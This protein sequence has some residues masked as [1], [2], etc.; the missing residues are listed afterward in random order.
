VRS[1]QD[2]LDENREGV[3]GTVASARKALENFASASEQIRAVVEENRASLKSTIA[4]AEQ[5]TGEMKG[6]AAENRETLKA[7]IANA[8]RMTRE[9]ADLVAENRATVKAALERIEAASGQVA[10]LVEENRRNI[11]NTTAKLPGAVD[12][13]SQAAGQIRDAVAE[14]RDDLRST[15]LGVAAFAPKLDRIGDNLEKIT[16]Q[17]ASGKGTVGRLVFEDTIHDQASS[18]LTSA[19]ERMDEIKPFTQGISELKLY[20]GLEGGSNVDSGMMLGEGYLR[21]EP[22][23]WKFYQAGASY[24]WAPTDRKVEKDDPNKLGVDFSLLIGWRFMPDDGIER[25]RLSVAGGLIETRLGGWADVAI[26]R[27][28]DIRLMARLKHNDREP[29]DRRYE[30]GDAMVRATAS[31]RMFDRIYAI[32]GWDD[33]T[34]QDAGPWFA[35]RAELLDNDLRNLST[36]SSIAR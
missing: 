32:A 20:A 13:L 3:K 24:R 35:L 15:M 7:S 2:I 26:T 8:E 17:V 34:G 1:L 36:A 30:H 23:S 28:L 19:Q 16:A 9:I 25:Y 21:I 14:N 6:I 5:L 11:Q 27:D 31:Y 10:A 22:R 29:T 18:V 4:N 12:N 33:C